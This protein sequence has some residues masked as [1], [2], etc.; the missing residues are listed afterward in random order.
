MSIEDAARI[1]KTISEVQY[2]LREDLLDSLVSEGEDLKNTLDPRS[3]SPEMDEIRDKF[4]DKLAILQGIVNELANFNLCHTTR[5]TRIDS[6]SADTHEELTERVNKKLARLE[7]CRIVDVK[8]LKDE[9]TEE[10]KWVSFVT[11][12]PN[13]LR[14]AP[15]KQPSKA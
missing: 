10:V 15:A 11:Y 3:F 6:I 1:A 14:P 2:E 4:L 5:I 13:P 8:F 12:M 9:G 7:G